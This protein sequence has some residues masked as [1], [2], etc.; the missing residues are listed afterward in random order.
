MAFAD[1]PVATPRATLDARGRREMSSPP[2]RELY[3]YLPNGM[4]R[5]KLTERLPR[6]GIA[7]TIST[8]RNWR[9][10]E[11]LSS[12]LSSQAAPTSRGA[13]PDCPRG[14]RGCG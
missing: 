14:R 4:G 12:M 11:M 9:T 6:P 3:L 7:G 13:D 8:V 1:M 10:V 2:G 5:T